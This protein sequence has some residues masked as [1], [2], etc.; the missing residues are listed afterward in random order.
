M[1]LKDRHIRNIIVYALPKFLGYAINLITLPILTRL[2]TPADYGVITLAWLF[3]SLATGIL[4][5]GLG[6]AAQRFYFEYRGDPGRLDVLFS[7]SQL[8]LYTVFIVSSSAVFV[9]KTDI[10]GLAIKDPGLGQAVFIAFIAA[11]LGQ[12][13]N[14]YLLLYQSMEQARVCSVMSGAQTLIIAGLSLLLVWWLRLGYMG[15]L[16]ASL[17]GETLVCVAVFVHFNRGRKMLFRPGILVENLRFGLQIVPKSLTGF[18]NRFFDK[19]M[20]NNMLSLSAVGVYN[21]GQNIGNALFILMNTV[22]S[23]FQPVCYAEVF[24]KGAAGSRSVGRI[25]TVFAYVTLAPV[26]LA[27]L[28][29]QEAVALLAPPAY[30]PAVDVMIVICAAIATNVFGMYVGVQYAYTKKA[31]WIFPVSLAG[32]L[33]NV[34]ANI[35]LIPRF[36]LIGAGVSV[37]ATY[38]AGNLLLTVIGQ[39]LYAIGYEWKH[40]ILFFGHLAASIAVILFLRRQGSSGFSLYAVKAVLLSLF[41]WIGVRAGII[42]RSTPGRLKTILKKG[43]RHDCQPEAQM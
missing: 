14:F 10:A 4:T 40:L 17:A 30:Y 21:I 28:F 24:D 22:W 5:C 1:A 2:L 27:V 35:L 29:A 20:L 38:A 9:F 36:G 19:Y 32:T 23:S 6:T 31:Y 26:L 34:A 39:R 11:F 15:M 13:I 37:V 18:I 7:S 33:V 41:L 25:F 12:I 42:D 43:S 8:F 3:P 16:Y